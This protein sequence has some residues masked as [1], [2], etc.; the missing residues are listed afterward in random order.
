MMGTPLKS[1][2]SPRANADF[3]SRYTCQLM[4]T[5][6][7][8]DPVTETIIP[9]QSKRKSRC[10]RAANEERFEGGAALVLGTG[11]VGSGIQR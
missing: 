1:P 6:C 5:D 2:T 3:V 7:I 8:C 11:D 10:F 4:A 9:N